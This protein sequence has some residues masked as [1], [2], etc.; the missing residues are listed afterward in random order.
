MKF[1]H[2]LYDKLIFNKIKA[3]IGGQIKVL[4]SAAAP[5]DPDLIVAFKAIYG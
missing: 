5:I 3:S 1:N 4:V 2:F